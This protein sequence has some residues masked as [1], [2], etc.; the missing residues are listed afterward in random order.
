MAKGNLRN[1]SPFEVR[2]SHGIGGRQS[3]RFVR[4]TMDDMRAN[5]WRGDPIEIIEHNGKSYIYDGNHR[6]Y[7]ARRV[8]LENIPAR[9]VEFRPRPGSWQSIEELLMDAASV[10]DKIRIR[11]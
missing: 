8:G 4:D 2:R 1:V 7:S 6:I 11:K 5:G 10:R 3:S 9:V